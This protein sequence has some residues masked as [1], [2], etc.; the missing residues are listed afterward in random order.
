MIISHANCMDG[1]VATWLANKVL[2]LPEDQ[3]IFMIYDEDKI[4]EFLRSEKAKDQD[5]YMLDFSFK[6]DKLLTLAQQAKS[7]VILDHHKTAEQELKEG[8]RLYP[9]HVKVIF[10]MTKSGCKLAYEYFKKELSYIFW[11][12]TPSIRLFID[13]VEDRDLWNWKLPNSRLY[14]LALRSYEL[15]GSDI[16]INQSFQTLDEIAKITVGEMVTIGANLERYQNQLIKQ[17]LKSTA[18]VI[19]EGHVI[20]VVNSCLFQSEIG[21]QLCKIIFVKN[22]K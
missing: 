18:E 10:D 11:E 20:L 21:E 6:K 2:N 19:I 5:I 15:F 9:N 17:A 8:E 12:N 13:Y 1:L 4:E 7:I 3:I 22:I 14:N 16:T